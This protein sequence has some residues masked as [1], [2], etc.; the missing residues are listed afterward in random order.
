MHANNHNHRAILQEI[1]HRAMRERGLLPDFSAEVLAELERL[2]LSAGAADSATIRDMRDLLWA[3]IDNDDSHDLDQLTVAEEMPSGQIKVFVAI[4]DVDSSVKIGSA[5]DQH[6]R[7]NTTSVYTAAEIF[8]MLPEKVS[9]DITSLNFDQDRLAIVV[10]MLVG[11][12]GLLEDAKIYRAWVHNYAQLA[13]NSLAAWLEKKGAIPQAIVAVQGL[14]ENL[15]LQDR[16]AQSLHDLRH[17]NGALSLET[18][19]AKPV[20]DGDQIR[21]LEVEE[22]NRAKEIIEDFMIA[23]NGVTARYLSA[24]NFPSIRRVV[25]TPKR[26]ERIVEIAAN[27]KVTLPSLPN[28]KALEEFLIKQKA[29][30]PLRFPDLSLAVIKLLGAGEYIAELPDGNAPGHF[31]LAVKDYAHSTAPN[32]RFS[33]L[34]TQR[35]LKAALEGKPA[36]YRKEELD[37]LATHCTQAEDDVNKVERQVGKSAAALLLESRIGEQFDAIVT[38]ASAKG[39]W[40]RLLEVPVEGKLVHGFEGQDVGNRL[41]VQLIAVNVEKGFIDF[42]RISSPR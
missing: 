42:R 8:P 29:A 17:I 19:E 11:A 16:A 24:N 35:L 28:S 30:D 38:G 34:I 18:I 23:A 6:A 39:T 21:A 20:F 22:K 10:E 5:M 27:Y 9:T 40:A 3:S 14:A 2:P 13:Y 41:R 26:W 32:R 7:T 36:P 33:D 25:R 1:A 4:A 15:Q 31:G 37:K 12:G